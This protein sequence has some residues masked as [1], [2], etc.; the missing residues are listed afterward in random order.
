MLGLSGQQPASTDGQSIEPLEAYGLQ[1]MS[2]GFMIDSETPMVWRGPMVTQALEQLLKETNWRD[3]DYLVIDLPPGTGDTQ[4]TLAQKV[5]SPAP[6]SS[7][8]RR[9]SP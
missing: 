6:S 4:L 7:R 8:R 9:T 5:P 2:I 3:L 1:V